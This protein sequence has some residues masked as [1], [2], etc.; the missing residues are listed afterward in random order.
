MA[1]KTKRNFRRHSH[2]ENR[3]AVIPTTVRLDADPDL[4]GR[5][6]T[7]AFLDAGFYPHPDLTKP[8]NR[9]LAYHD[10]TD[11]DAALEER[12]R[13]E[14]WDWH[15]TQTSV[16]AA[17]N[18][19]LSERIYRGIASD[20][21]V[22]LV[23]VSE[24]G[25]IT[26]QNIARGLQWV[27][28]N[29]DNYDIR[30]VSISLGGDQ[31]VP[32]RENEVDQLAEEAVQHGIVIVVAAGNSGCTDRHHTV[33]PANSPSVITVGGYDDENQLL[34]MDL[35]L[36][37]SSFGPTA[38]GLIKPEIVA[39]AMW[40]AAPI[41]P[42]TDFYRRAEAL[43][44]LAAAPEYKLVSLAAKLGKIA[45]CPPAIIE[46]GV[47]HIRSFVEQQMRESK[48]VSTHYQHVDG[49]SFAAPTVAS[50]VAQMLE[51]N[52][53]LKPLAVKNLLISTAERI[54]NAPL[55]RQG[56]G[57]LNARTAVAQAV[58]EH[59]HLESASYSAPRIQD[60]KL[61]FLYHHDSASNV[62]L[63]GDFNN[64]HASDFQKQWDGI[65]KA[66]IPLPAPGRYR[67][68]FILNGEKW[69]DDPGNGLKEPDHYGGFNSVVSVM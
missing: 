55:L 56:Y 12:K 27:I 10:V 64:W 53:G 65:W 16:S 1:L 24:R 4:T 5:G 49:T 18:G 19:F 23:K 6:V 36:Y 69:V 17:G 60:D 7:I 33:P 29:K 40:V 35:H 48:L 14:S 41:L 46:A 47:N 11:P 67:Y 31:D 63:A 2:V 44:Q 59:H 66:E 50:V 34:N 45:K 39:P 68:K 22:V 62:L 61:V 51:A 8:H 26:E 38:D 25:K 30:I 37:C 13:P 58:A 32:Y 3:F 20:A 52:P 57:K 28:N 15:G 42:R 43:S 54:R 21:N 9:I